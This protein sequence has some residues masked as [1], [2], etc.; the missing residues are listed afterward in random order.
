ME[1]V[2]GGELFDY[3]VEHAPLSLAEIVD[4]FQQIIL[5]V[6]YCHDCKVVHRDLKPEN[7]LL[8]SSHNVKLADFGMAAWEGDISLLS[9][10][11]GS[12]HYA[13]PEIINGDKYKGA[14]SD[15]WS[16]GVI[17]HALL[18]GRLP[19]DDNNIVKLLEKVRKA[20]FEMPKDICEEAKDLLSRMLERDVEKRIS[21][22]QIMKHPFYLKYAPRPIYATDRSKGNEHNS[23]AI[24]SVS[25]IDIDIFGNLRALWH[26]TSDRLIVKA[27]MSQE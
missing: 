23:E 2:E 4:Y 20:E 12:P 18:V 7:I 25:E 15:V 24:S 19:F 17:L 14:V 21:I 22:P 10:A 8:D 13:S 9:T 27:L 11:C 3:I 6:Q 16:C 1:Y 26:G 5:A